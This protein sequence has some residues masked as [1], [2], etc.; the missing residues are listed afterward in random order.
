MV[1]RIIGFD[2]VQPTGEDSEMQPHGLQ[3]FGNYRTTV[4]LPRDDCTYDFRV[5]IQPQG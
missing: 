2:G 1:V 3:V 5:P 4:S